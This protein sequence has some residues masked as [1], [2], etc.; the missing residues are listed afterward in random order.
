[1]RLPEREQTR[2]YETY[3]SK[4]ENLFRGS[5]HTFDAFI[6]DYIAL[7]TQ[8]SKQEKT[9]QIYFAFRRVFG[10]IGSDQGKLDLFLQEL[11]R[12]AHYHAA[13][14]IGTDAPEVLRQP[15]AHLRRQ[16]DVPATLIMRLFECCDQLGT[17]SSDQFADAIE[18]IDSY[19]FRRAIC[20][21]Q[22]RGLLA[23]FC[24]SRVWH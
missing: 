5:E 9:D 1:M 24:E 8:A 6:R 16:V 10:P 13:F 23:G 3:W 22:T 15:L 21:E 2:L 19:V 12:F 17:L 20:G 4:I 18:L 11:L 7:R 14:S